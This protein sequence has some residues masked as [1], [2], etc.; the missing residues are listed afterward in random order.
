[1]NYEQ[2]IYI[3]LELSNSYKE[4][5]FTELAN[6]FIAVRNTIIELIKRAEDSEERNKTL[7]NQLLNCR[8]QITQLELQLH[9]VIR[10]FKESGGNCIYCK[11]YIGNFKCG[12]DEP[13]GVNNNFEWKG[14]GD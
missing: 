5:G 6:I 13:C 11:H 3:L 14:S 1:M 12:N 2:Q 8:N 4:E 7:Y 9:D 10:D